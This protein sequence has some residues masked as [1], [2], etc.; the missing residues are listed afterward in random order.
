MKKGISLLIIA[1]IAAGSTNL[2]D[3]SLKELVANYK[4]VRQQIKATRT[5]KRAGTATAAELAQ[6]KENR[7]RIMKRAAIAGGA[8]AAAFAAAV[9][10]G[11]AGAAYARQKDAQPTRAKQA[12]AEADANKD[13]EETKEEFDPQ[14]YKWKRVGEK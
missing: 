14:G 10:L 2:I 6:L 7:R 11:A 1:A 4:A 13:W 12:P 5:K 8:T 3:A 9:G